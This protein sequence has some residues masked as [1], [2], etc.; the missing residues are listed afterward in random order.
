MIVLGGFDCTNASFLLPKDK[1]LY[2]LSIAAIFNTMTTR[3][4]NQTLGGPIPS[5]RTFHTAVKSNVSKMHAFYYVCIFI[6]FYSS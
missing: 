6:S 2:P 1:Y 4:Y 3:W 5:A